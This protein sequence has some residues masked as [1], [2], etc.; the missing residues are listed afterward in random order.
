MLKG[1]SALL[2]FDQTLDTPT[3]VVGRCIN[4]NSPSIVSICV[5]KAKT[6][7]WNGSELATGIFKLPVEGKIIARTL[8]L[9][10]DEQADL[11]VHGGADKAV[12]AYPVEQYSFWKAE[13]PERKFEWGSFGENLTTVGFDENSVCIGDRLRVGTAQFVVTQPRMPCFKL[14]IRLGDP[15]MVRRFYKSGKWGFYLAVTEEGEIETGDQIISEGG[16]GHRITLADVA[17]CFIRPDVELLS[18]VLNS[19]LAAQMKD[20]LEYQH[21]K[22]RRRSSF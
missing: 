17:Q 11:T 3:H 6:V 7:N 20:Q 1:P 16:D 12:Y 5:S 15:G 8:N 14:G 4:L 22:T 13:M 9:E 19:N 2:N 10:G 21:S 18:R